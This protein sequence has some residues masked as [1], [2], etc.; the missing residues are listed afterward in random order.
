MNWSCRSAGPCARFSIASGCHLSPDE[1][2]QERH[3]ADTFARREFWQSVVGIDLQVAETI[4]NGH[5]FR[6][7][8]RD[9]RGVLLE[10]RVA[11]GIAIGV[12]SEAH[13]V[14]GKFLAR[15]RRRRRLGDRFLRRMSRQSEFFPKRFLRRHLSGRVFF[16]QRFELALQLPQ[17]KRQLQLRRDKQRLHEKDGRDE[18]HNRGDE[19]S[20]AQPRPAFARWIGENERRDCVARAW[21][22]Y[23]GLLSLRSGRRKLW[24][25]RARLAP[26]TDIGLIFSHKSATIPVSAAYSLRSSCID[27]SA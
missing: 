4:D 1:I 12:K 27:R 26:V 14:V 7:D 24:Q 25:E 2:C 8:M 22:H 23:E 13:F 19:Q 6:T 11:V 20:E 17:R 10:R 15:M 21:L 3:Q 5:P 9:L 18:N 16:L